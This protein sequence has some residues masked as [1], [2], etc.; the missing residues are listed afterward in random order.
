MTSSCSSKDGSGLIY[1]DFNYETLRTNN[2][3]KVQDYY[4]N[5]LSKYT[6]QYNDYLTKSTSSSQ[7]DKDQ[8]N[9]MVTEGTLPK[10]NMHLIDVINEMNAKVEEDITNLQAQQEKVNRDNEIILANRKLIDDLNRALKMKSSD[11]SKNNSSYNE[12]NDDNKFNSYCEIFFIIVNILIFIG[13]CWLI[14]KVLY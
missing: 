8:A 4:N 2:L 7:A 5:V 14:Y 11:I 10:M 13:L 12:T 9:Y 6:T 1:S 3:Q